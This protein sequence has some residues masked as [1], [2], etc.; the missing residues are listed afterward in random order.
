MSLSQ[1]C[2]RGSLSKYN[3]PVIRRTDPAF[4][5]KHEVEPRCLGKASLVSIVSI[6]SM[7]DKV[8]DM[9]HLS[10]QGICTYSRRAFHP[11]FQ[12]LLTLSA[13]WELDTS[14][15]IVLEVDLVCVAKSSCQAKMRQQIML[16]LTETCSRQRR[17]KT[18][19]SER[20]KFVRAKKRIVFMANLTAHRNH[21]TPKHPLIA[22]LVTNSL[23]A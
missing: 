23:A 11:D 21:T 14:W 17:D 20:S 16:A 8:K 19:S 3:G 12:H 6:S 13:L 7:L 5:A 22:M 18:K 9:I 2:L 4:H 15:G 10:K 1:L